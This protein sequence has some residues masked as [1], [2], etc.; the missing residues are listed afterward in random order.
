MDEEK[1]VYF[2]KGAKVYIE[3]KYSVENSA[4]AI[5]NEWKDLSKVVN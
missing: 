4:K 3:N 5:R 2:G 1:V